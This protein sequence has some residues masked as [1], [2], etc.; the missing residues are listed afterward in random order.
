MA[1][2]FLRRR[3]AAYTTPEALTAALVERAIGQRATAREQIVRGYDSEVYAVVAERGDELVVRIRRHGGVGYASEAWA[4][5]QCRAAGVPV[6]EVLLLD[7]IAGDDGSHEAMV[8]RQLAGR[9]LSE[10]LPTLTSDQRARLFAELGAALSAMHGIAVGGFYR[11]HAN[12]R[13]DFPDWQSVMAS[14]IAERRA[15]A[16]IIEHCGFSAAEVAAMLNMMERYRDEFA[17]PQPVLCHSDLGADHIFVSHDGHLAGLIDFGDF[18]GGTPIGDIAQLGVNMPQLDLRLLQP[19]YSR[20]G[21][22]DER[23][24]RHL[25]LHNVGTQMGYLAHYVNQKMMHEVEPAVRGLR[26][27]LERWQTR[28]NAHNV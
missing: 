24:E 18:A 12:D 21:V 2:E 17:C 4:L 16:P 1:D 20:P 26:L 10:R 5:E 11:R 19:G 25:L 15:E 13:W 27:T 23:F 22:F 8:Q 6:P 14:H 9:P 7:T 3:H 28:D